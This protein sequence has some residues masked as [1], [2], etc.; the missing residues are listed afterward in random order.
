MPNSS[1]EVVGGFPQIDIGALI[2]QVT[3]VKRGPAT[4][5]NY[6]QAGPLT[7]FTTVTTAMA[8]LNISGGADAV[9]GG[10][11]IE[12][13]MIDVTMYYQSGITPDMQVQSDNGSQYIIK[14]VENV[15]E[16]NIVLVLHCL[17]L[18]Q[19]AL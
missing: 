10:L 17:G 3:I 11:T 19:N 6:D 13:L 18:R 5:P 12:E 16:R 15:L 9:K 14:S 4:P 1:Y 2:H 8:A 7:N